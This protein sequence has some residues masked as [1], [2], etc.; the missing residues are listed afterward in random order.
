[1][2]PGLGRFPGEGK[3][4]PLQCSGLENSMEYIV[5]GVAKSRTGLSDFHFSSFPP[6]WSAYWILSS[7]R[8][9][10]PQLSKT[11]TPGEVRRLIEPIRVFFFFFLKICFILNLWHVYLQVEFNINTFFMSA[12][13][14]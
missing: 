13:R 9:A 8:A 7:P 2:I 5:H 3:G 4:Y 11:I 10:R 14:L 12:M 6:T 1:M